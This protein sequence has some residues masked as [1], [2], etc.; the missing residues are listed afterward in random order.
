MWGC[1]S[2]KGGVLLSVLY[3]SRASPTLPHLSSDKRAYI[4][5]Y[6]QTWRRRRTKTEKG[7]PE[8]SEDDTALETPG[9]VS[10][11]WMS[12]T[13]SL[14]EV[15]LTIPSGGKATGRTPKT[16]SAPSH[17]A[18]ST[19]RDKPCRLCASTSATALRHW[20]AVAIL[21]SREEIL[22]RRVED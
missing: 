14:Q 19:C 12:P 6:N 18:A 13:G 15:A 10:I 1:V 9:Q 8:H 2:S 21:L 5:A 4:Q 11:C 20:G 17:D 3:G 22:S 16:P 7:E